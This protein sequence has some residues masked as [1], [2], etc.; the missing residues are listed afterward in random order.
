MAGLFTE[1]CRRSLE[2]EHEEKSHWERDASNSGPI[3]QI[4][5]QNRGLE[6][7]SGSFPVTCFVCNLNGG[8]SSICIVILETNAGHLCISAFIV[9]MDLRSSVWGTNRWLRDMVKDRTAWQIK[10]CTWGNKVLKQ[11][12]C[13]A[14]TFPMG[15]KMSWS[16]TECNQFPFTCVAPIARSMAQIYRICLESQWPVTKWY[17]SL[18]WQLG[19]VGKGGDGPAKTP[20]YCERLRIDVSICYSTRRQI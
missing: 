13:Q 6:G 14:R 19:H 7:E 1:S 18:I 10:A 8:S 20:Q 15:Y 12:R 4:L 11:K 9:R 3:G 2:V 17:L 5:L 16:N